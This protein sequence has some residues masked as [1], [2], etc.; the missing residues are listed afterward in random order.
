MSYIHLKD[1]TRKWFVLFAVFMSGT[2][3]IGINNYSF[4]FFIE[5]LEKEFGWSRE[6]ISLGYSFSFIS[7]LLAPLVGKL[8]DLKGSKIFLVLSLFSIALGF[9]LRP[10]MLN[11]THWIVLN[12]LVFAGYPGALYF[13]VGV[14]VQ[15]WFPES[16]GRMVAIA[17]SGHNVGGTLFPLITFIFFLFFNWK[18][19]YF[20]Y[21]V[22]ILLVCIFSFLFVEN[23]PDKKDKNDDEDIAKVGIDF[24]SAIRSKKFFFLTLGITFANFTY[25]AVLPQM[26]PHLQKVG[27]STI[28]SSCAMVYIGAMGI[29]SKLFF[30][31][32]SERFSSLLLSCISIFL[33]ALGLFLILIAQGNVFGIWIGI[34]VFGMGFGGLGTLISLN[35]TECFGL[36]CLSSIWGFLLFL[37]IWSAFLGPWMM[38]KSF[39]STGSY[40]VAH[41]IIVGIFCCSIVFLFVTKQLNKRNFLLE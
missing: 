20:V 27:L 39:T 28:A 16:R 3:I 29:V 31:K 23:H 13:S 21:G 33:Q 26:L 22:I 37:G 1:A 7:S 2:L 9:L 6:Q 41:S 18:V 40:L 12:A 36:R 15:V 5:P 24:R 30:G 34:L 17:T 35:I 11:L 4:G 38:G 14:L 25:F 8:M 10:F 32:I 19:T